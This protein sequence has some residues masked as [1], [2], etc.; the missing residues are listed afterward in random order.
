MSK[1]NQQDLPLNEKEERTQSMNENKMPLV[2]IGTDEIDV[3]QHIK[4]MGRSIEHYKQIK[5]LSLKLT[6]EADWVFQD[7]QPY[8]M[9]RGAEQIGIAWGVDIPARPGDKI[10]VE[11]IEKEDSKGKY[12][13]YM[14]KGSAYSKKLDRTV[15]DI[16]TCSER[17]KF[18]TMAQGKPIELHKVDV[19]NLYKKAVTNLHNRLIKRVT[20]IINADLDDLK[21]AGLDVSKIA[22]IEYKKGQKKADSRLSKEDLNKREEMYNLA[23]EIAQGDEKRAQ[24]IISD[25]SKFTKGEKEYKVTD[26]KQ[27]RTSGWIKATHNKI[28]KLYEEANK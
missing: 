24:N 11:V 3:E 12:K 7:K 21:E 23:L 15:S 8:L 19:T 26:V 18:F 4:V 9:D 16:G 13:L 22:K 6:K 2:N 10:E 20:G 1:N 27:L 14:A 25:A 28:S 17:D 5:V